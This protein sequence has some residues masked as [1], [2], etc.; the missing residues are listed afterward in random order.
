[1]HV[2]ICSR[3][4][5]TLSH[6]LFVLRRIAILRNVAAKMTQHAARGTAYPY[7]RTNLKLAT[8]HGMLE[9][10]GVRTV[11]SRTASWSAW[12]SVVL[13]RVEERG[14]RADNRLNIPF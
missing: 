2:Q 10:I 8:V 7:V 5:F 1:M 6:W 12:C 3:A 11:Q 9:C 14:E 13:S 4:G